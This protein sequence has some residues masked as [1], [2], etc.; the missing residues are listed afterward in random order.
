MLSGS[1]GKAAAVAMPSALVPAPAG[2]SSPPKE[3]KDTINGV[4]ANLEP[5]DLGSYHI[6]KDN[7]KL[8]REMMDEMGK[9]PSWMLLSP[10]FQEVKKKMVVV[11]LQTKDGTEATRL[12][13]AKYGKVKGE[14]ADLKSEITT[15]KAENQRVK[16]ER[17][18]GAAA[19]TAWKSR[20]LAEVRAVLER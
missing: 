20:K 14:V 10:E 1:S 4:M 16:R 5:S 12:L 3:G 15:L 18:A 17:D 11:D 19:N 13:T 7:R 9:L 2:G 8:V 6:V